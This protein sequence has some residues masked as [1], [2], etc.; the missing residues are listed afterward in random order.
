MTRLQDGTYV[1]VFDVILRSDRLGY[2][3]SPDGRHWSPAQ[4][5]VLNSAQS[6]VSDLRTPLGLIDEGS[7]QFTLH[8]TGYSDLPGVGKYGSLGM[9]RLK[10]VRP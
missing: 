10:L 3:T 4:Y 1:A 9:L 5:L 2:T 6:W 8:Y 7:G